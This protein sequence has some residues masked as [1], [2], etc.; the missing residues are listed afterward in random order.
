MNGAKKKSGETHL[1]IF[2]SP[3]SCLHLVLSKRLS[4]SLPGRML[5]ILKPVPAGKHMG[6][7]KNRGIPKWM[8]KI[9][10][11]PNMDDLG[12]KPPIFGN[13]HI[14]TPIL[15]IYSI[16][17]S[18]TFWEWLEPWVDAQKMDDKWEISGKGHLHV[19]DQ[20]GLLQKES[21]L[22]LCPPNRYKCTVQASCVFV[23]QIQESYE[24]NLPT[25][26]YTSCFMVIGILI[27]AYFN[28]P[29][30]WVVQSPLYS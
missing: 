10:E 27:M 12:G 13:T 18:P 19:R 21:P 29:Y 2:G 6:G 25:F 7:S 15:Y 3:G 23:V 20:S 28:S 5:E 17:S 16:Y 8:V 4:P 9:M 22:L 14:A 24:K 11:N 1:C 30:K 26:H